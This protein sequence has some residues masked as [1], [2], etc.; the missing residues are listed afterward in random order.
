MSLG[1]VTR[2]EAGGLGLGC[3]QASLIL[4][5]LSGD[6]IRELQPFSKSNEDIKQGDGCQTHMLFVAEIVGFLY[7]AWDLECLGD[8]RSARVPMAIIILPLW[9]REEQGGTK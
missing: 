8:W 2:C 7:G 3:T 6:S 9:G 4:K 5:S 1:T